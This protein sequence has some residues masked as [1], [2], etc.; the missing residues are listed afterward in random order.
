MI[1]K[2]SASVTQATERFGKKK[3]EKRSSSSRANLKNGDR[4]TSD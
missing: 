1:L 3:K 2:L 4:Q